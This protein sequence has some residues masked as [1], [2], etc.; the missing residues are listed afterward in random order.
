MRLRP[1]TKVPTAAMCGAVVVLTGAASAS[2]E[3]G[4]PV[5][6]DRP[7]A[8]AGSWGVAQEVPG[9]ASLN[10]GGFARIMSVSCASSG[11]C[12][13]GGYYSDTPGHMQAMVV[14][15][16]NGHWG[17][18]E[19]VPGTASLNRGGEA[20][21][22]SL[23]C[24][25]PGDCSGGG[26][27]TGRHRRSEA[28]VVTQVNGRWGSA[29]QVPGTAALN[30]AGN[31]ETYAVSCTSAG[32]CGAGGRYE[33]HP[34]SYQ[35]FVVTEQRGRWSRAEEVPGTGALNKGGMATVNSISCPSAGNCSAGGA[36]ASRPALSQLFVVTQRHGRWGKA[37]QAPGTAGLSKD[38]DDAVYSIS[39]TSAGTCAASAQYADQS[40]SFQA[41][42]LTER[43]GKWAKALRVRGLAG[44]GASNS[45][46][47]DMSCPS[48]GNCTT[49]GWY[50]VPAVGHIQAF[51]ISERQ[52][53]WGMAQ[54]VPGL[55]VLNAGN[56]AQ[57]Q[58]VACRSAG[59]CS[60][61]GYY[62]ESFG[63]SAAFV[64]NQINGRWGTAEEVPG[65]A[66]LNTGNLATV[67]SISCAP[68]GTCSAG[69]AYQDSAGYQ[70]FV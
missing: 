31:A 52:G 56:N 16:K 25:R 23:S 10:V 54:N 41:L 42:I 20:Q 68:K 15:E 24:A 6:A 4:A 18:A 65:I 70:A 27:Y 7:A 2:A 17:T 48:A 36:Y 34:G 61:G 60:A 49:G 47:G 64:V 29:E 62:M 22:F 63:H 9:S 45:A 13:A 37:E 28:F 14:S 11:N 21:I 39:C 43:N 46:L 55:A 3:A 67:V 5:A 51:V 53:R 12:S 66:A 35:A 59:N 40:S 30:K 38:I 44:F 57:V 50:Y 8:S 19:E 1:G 58:P 26:Y 32:N 33:S 69:G